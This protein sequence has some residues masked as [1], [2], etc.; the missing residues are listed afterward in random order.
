MA[1]EVV[2]LPVSDINDTQ[3]SRMQSRKRDEEE[4]KKDLNNSQALAIQNYA[5]QKSIGMVQFASLTSLAAK[6]VKPMYIR[7]YVTI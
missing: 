4:R 2:G 7:M 1:W 3:V 6:L 5:M